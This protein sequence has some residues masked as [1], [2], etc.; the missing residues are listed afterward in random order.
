MAGGNFDHSTF[1]GQIFR[2]CNVQYLSKTTIQVK[3]AFIG[4]RQRCERHSTYLKTLTSLE[5]ITIEVFRLNAVCDLKD[6]LKVILTKNKIKR[7]KLIAKHGDKLAVS[8]ILDTIVKLALIIEIFEF[9]PS[10][11]QNGADYCQSISRITNLRHLTILGYMAGE[12]L[13]IIFDGLDKLNRIYISP[14]Y[15]DGQPT[16]NIIS[17]YA[18][19]HEKR[20]IDVPSF[21]K[22]HHTNNSN[23]GSK[24]IT[25]LESNDRSKI[26]TNIRFYGRPNGVM[27]F[28]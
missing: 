7:I 4:F 27:F 19:R 20:I 10:L 22:L 28:H 21:L 14:F 9:V 5:S 15:T 23:P 6:L 2:P 11:T 12:D 1:L 13:K 25:V 18:A 24:D 3:S 8:I 16:L 17:K 26:A